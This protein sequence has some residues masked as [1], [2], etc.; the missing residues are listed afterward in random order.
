[1]LIQLIEF[2]WSDRPAVKTNIMANFFQFLGYLLILVGNRITGLNSLNLS[3]LSIIISSILM[4]ATTFRLFDVKIPVKTFIMLGV[5]S[6]MILFVD[7]FLFKSKFPRILI[8]TAGLGLLFLYGILYLYYKSPSKSRHLLRVMSI[9]FFLLSTA[10]L[11]RF[12]FIILFFK[13]TDSFVSDD[14]AS[15]IYIVEM[16]ILILVWNYTVQLKRNSIFRQKLEKNVTDLLKT[17]EDISILNYFYHENS[18]SSSLDELYPKIFDLINERFSIAKA[19]LFVGLDKELVPVYHRG[20]SDIEIPILTHLDP[21]TSV[22]YKAYL[23]NEIKESNIEDYPDGELK[24]LLLAKGVLGVISFPLYTNGI[25]IGSFSVGINESTSVVDKDKEIF[26]SICT[27]VAGVIYNSKIHNSLLKAQDELKMLA[28]TD[29][30]TGIMNR[31]EFFRQFNK[32]LYSTQRY[33]DDIALFMIDLDDFKK[34]NDRY[35]HDAGDAVLIEVTKEVSSHLRENDIFARYGG[36][37]FIG[38]LLR[39]SREDA[40]NK[41]KKLIKRV[42]ITEIPGFPEIKITISIGCCYVN[43]TIRDPNIII[44]KADIALYKAKKMGKNRLCQTKN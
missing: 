6:F 20:I 21:E 33:Q 31:R 24:N 16:S 9:E 30:L 8:I 12:V 44:K 14:W 42:E 7:P 13:N 10:S 19:V 39:T 18:S 29:S 34:I 15:S 26:L 38:V 2:G 32:E 28:S 3:K 37:E 23:N 4:L 11:F 22:S 35:G 43:E 5:F 1:M 41:L 36:E 25:P 40:V 27:Q 17:Q